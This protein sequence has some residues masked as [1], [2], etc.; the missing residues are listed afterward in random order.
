MNKLFFAAI[1]AFAFTLTSCQ[2]CTDCA[3]VGNNTFEFADGMPQADQDFITDVYTQDYQDNSQELCEKR[4]D[5]DDAVSS[6]E[7]SSLSFE[8][9]QTYQGN[10]WSL[11]ASYDCTCEE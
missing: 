6:Y 11:K 1:A 7:A 2:K 4:G 3:C 10:D 8:E 9:S 5:F